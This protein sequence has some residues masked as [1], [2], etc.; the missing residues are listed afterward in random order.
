MERKTNYYYTA[1]QLLSQQKRLGERRAEGLT[2]PE[3]VARGEA[4][5][6]RRVAR[7]SMNNC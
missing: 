2:L 1:G 5:Q 7:S 6:E 4:S 3:G